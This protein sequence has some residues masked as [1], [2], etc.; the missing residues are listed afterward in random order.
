MHITPW[1]LPSD[2]RQ[3]DN[4]AHY[5]CRHSEGVDSLQHAL[6]YSLTRDMVKRISTQTL[7]NNTPTQLME[8]WVPAQVPDL[9]CYRTVN[10]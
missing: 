10:S 4:P 1:L 9:A 6:Y 2:S 8:T 7:L 5:P 3:G